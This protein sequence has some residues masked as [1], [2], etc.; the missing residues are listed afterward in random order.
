MTDW[1]F[2]EVWDRVAGATP[3][4]T[5]VVQ[6]S[7][8]RS[9]G[10]F[11]ARAAGVANGLRTAAQTRGDHGRR[12]QKVA[13]YLHNR[14]EYLES[15]YAAFMSRM[16]PVNTNFRF[17]PDELEYLWTNSD[18][19][20]VVFDASLT[21]AVEETRRRVPSVHTWVC[22]GGD[23]PPWAESYEAWALAPEGLAATERSGDDVFM[24]YTGGT[25]GLPKGV[26][27]RQDDMFCNLNATALHRY[28]EN[29]PVDDVPA[30]LPAEPPV[31]LTAC[32]LMHGAGSITSMSALSQGGTVVL[33]PSRSFSAVELLD[34]VENE[35]VRTVAITGDAIA[36]PVV[37]AL[38]AEPARWDLSSLVYIVSSAVTWSAEVKERLRRHC[39]GVKLVDT[40]G[41]SEGMGVGRS[42][43]GSGAQKPVT[44]DFLPGRHTEVLG[45]DGLPVKPGS[46]EPGMLVVGGRQ[47][48]GY[49]KDPVRSAEVWRIIRGRRYALTGDYATVEDDGSIKLMGR[50]S[51]SINS[52]GEKI[53]PGEVEAVVRSHPGV[54][55]VSVVGAP[56]DR[57]GEIVVAVVEPAADSGLSEAE[58][59]SYVKERLARYKAPRRVV[60]VPQIARLANGKFDYARLKAQVAE[61]Q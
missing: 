36:R 37:D 43:T 25:T 3:S 35:R 22:V 57:F 17:G 20:I 16:V 46:G 24:L 58:L 48:L 2:A 42:V 19:E 49:Y 40:L 33:L 45:E 54:R 52:G 28:P 30:L 56:D 9:W 44:G 11:R 14:P 18:S 27:W 55:D 53:Y 12:Q 13:L 31:H 61:S 32:P 29:A 39:P 7:T 47:P 1:N 51:A 4:R 59:I 6:G 21:G 10:D 26:E 38:D 8:R 50:G 15:V 41:A 34:T 60:F 23:V 5:A